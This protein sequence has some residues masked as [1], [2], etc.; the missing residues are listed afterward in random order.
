MKEV[1]VSAT[2]NDDIRFHP[3]GSAELLA[4]VHE[5]LGLT[6]DYDS[7]DAAE[8]EEASSPKVFLSY[9]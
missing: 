5:R 4:L 8:V 3:E 1:M 6:G 2:S 7:D 9:A